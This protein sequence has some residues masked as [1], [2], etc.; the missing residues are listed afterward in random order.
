MPIVSFPTRSARRAEE[1]DDEPQWVPFLKRFT[2]F[3]RQQCENLPE[4]LAKVPAPIP[5]LLIL[6]QAEALV[7]KNSAPK[8]RAPLCLARHRADRAAHRLPRR[9]A[10]LMLTSRLLEVLRE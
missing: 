5:D 4:D 10:R 9:R 2:V 3:N 7:R 1:D 6:P 8:W